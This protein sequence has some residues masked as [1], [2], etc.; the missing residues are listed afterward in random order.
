MLSDGDKAEAN[1]AAGPAGVD[2]VAESW[3]EGG[4]T[5][6]GFAAAVGRDAYS[7]GRER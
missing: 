2:S 4:G 1:C 3:A 6:T 7:A 5:L